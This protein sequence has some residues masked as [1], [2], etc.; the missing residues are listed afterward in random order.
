MKQLIGLILALGT[1]I[2]AVLTAAPAI[3]T[4]IPIAAGF[5]IYGADRSC[6]VSF[7]DPITPDVVYTAAHCYTPGAPTIVYSDNYRIGDYIPAI[8]NSVV[9]LIAIRLRSSVS[10]P[11]FLATGEPLLDN[12]VANAGGTVC[13]YS[14]RHENCGKVLEANSDRFN[15]DMSADPADSGAPI[16]QREKTNPESGVHVVGILIAE[17]EPH[18][19]VIVCSAMSPINSFLSRTHRVT[20]DR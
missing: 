14:K 20:W 6:T 11:Q 16:Y 4:A 13:K 15:V 10:S 18:S 12:W 3:V 1:T 9:D 17:T 2:A 7:P 8:S 5:T 19:G